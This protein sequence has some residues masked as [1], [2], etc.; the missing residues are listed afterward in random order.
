MRCMVVDAH[1]RVIA[2]NSD[3]APD[4]VTLPEG[5]T[6]GFYVHDTDLIGYA[7]T[8]GYETY[9][10]LGWYGVVIERGGA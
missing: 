4:T 1:Q 6:D 9:R 2:A 10:G 3:D 5:P 7:R 8:P